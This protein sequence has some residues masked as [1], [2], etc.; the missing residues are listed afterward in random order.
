MGGLQ[1][2]PPH[3]RT[4]TKLIALKWSPVCWTPQHRG[5]CFTSPFQAGENLCEDAELATENFGKAES[6]GAAKIDPNHFS[7]LVLQVGNIQASYIGRS[8]P[9]ASCAKSMI[10]SYLAL[11]ERVRKIFSD[12]HQSLILLIF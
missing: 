1:W 5:P 2:F 11:C 7:A 10:H 6:C 12:P 4:A 9:S 3:T 8:S